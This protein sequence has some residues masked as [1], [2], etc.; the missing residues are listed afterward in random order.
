MCVGCEVRREVETQVG[1][2]LAA[3]F[4]R[5]RQEKLEATFLQLFAPDTTFEQMAGALA[6]LLRPG[7]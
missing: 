4:N 7:A 2:K 1:M 3:R 6:E 5:T